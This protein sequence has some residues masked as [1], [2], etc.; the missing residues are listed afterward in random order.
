MANDCLFTTL[1]FCNI[2]TVIKC[3]SLSKTINIINTQYLWK[4]LCE[5][6][7]ELLDYGNFV[8]IKWHDKYTI[9]YLIKPLTVYCAEDFGD[10]YIQ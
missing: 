8:D 10:I 7:H 6:D 2:K 9:C 1:L 3:V 4:L 5:R